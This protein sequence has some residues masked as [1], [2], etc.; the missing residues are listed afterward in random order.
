VGNPPMPS[1]GVSWAVQLIANL[2]IYVDLFD[3]FKLK[4]FNNTGT[5]LRTPYLRLSGTE[6]N[7]R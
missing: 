7:K 1:N 4:L 5:A 3:S 2:W 6:T